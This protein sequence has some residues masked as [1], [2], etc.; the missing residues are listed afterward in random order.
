M[1]MGQVFALVRPTVHAMGWGPP[2]WATAPA[3]AYVAAEAPGSFVD[4]RV[5]VLRIG[6]L[7]LCMGAAFILDDA[8]EDTIG[9]VST[10]LV[11]RRVLRVLLVLPTFTL[12]W[13][14]LVHLAGDVAKRDGGP[15]PVGDLTLE[16]AT[17]LLIAMVAACL[18]AR[19]TSDRLGGVVAAPV[20]LACAGVAMFLPPDR[21]PLLGSVSDPRWDHV[22]DLWGWALLGTGLVF[23]VV[24]R[25]GARRLTPLHLLLTGADRL[26]RQLRT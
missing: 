4:Y 21:R 18:G 16:V 24:N 26:R 8:T 1:R 15:L 17:L 23:L 11:V 20:L 13:T 7:L 6:A 22:H 19:F 25:G 5:Q 3:L 12:G 10:P 14:A 2:L 9:Y